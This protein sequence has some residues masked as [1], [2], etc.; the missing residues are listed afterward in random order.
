MTEEEKQAKEIMDGLGATEEELAGA[1]TKISAAFKG[2][3][4]RQAV[5]EKKANL[6]DKKDDNLLVEEKKEESKADPEEKVEEKKDEEKKE[7]SEKKE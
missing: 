2:K 6:E 1:A 7:E 5:A 3:K 4:A